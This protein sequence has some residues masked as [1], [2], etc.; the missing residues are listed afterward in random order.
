[1]YHVE[2]EAMQGV[3]KKQKIGGEMGSR[4]FNFIKMFF[5]LFGFVNIKKAFLSLQKSTKCY[6]HRF[7]ERLWKTFQ[8]RN[9][10]GLVV[11]G[12]DACSKGRG[13]ESRRRILDG[14]DIFSHAF[15][16]KI[17]LFVWKRPKINIKEAEDGPFLKK[18]KWPCKVPWCLP[19]ARSDWATF[20]RS[21]LHIFLQK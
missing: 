15:V 7:G 1:M 6:L 18:K 11:M 19:S 17:V 5:S 20:E 8:S 2:A 10:P 3:N 12:G 9:G 21:W 4:L 13:F 16:V 14:H